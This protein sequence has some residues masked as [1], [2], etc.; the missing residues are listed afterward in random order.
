[1]PQNKERIA[2][3]LNNW[4]TKTREQILQDLAS[5]PIESANL[6][7]EQRVNVV[8]LKI[9]SFERLLSP[10]SQNP[11]D[12]ATIK[13]HKWALKSKPNIEI[14]TDSQDPSEVEIIKAMESFVDFNPGQI[15]VWISPAEKGIYD[16]SR[17]GIYQTILV[18]NEKYLFFR[19]LCG[20][21]YVKE[22]ADIAILFLAHSREKIETAELLNP[23]VLRATPIILD[24]PNKSLIKFLGSFIK[25][26]ATWE[27]ILKA[28]DI[29]MKIKTFKVAYE[30]ISDGTFQQIQQ[31]NEFYQQVQIGTQLERELQEKLNI[32]L[33]SGSCGI[34]Y[35]SIN[36]NPLA[37]ILGISTLNS[38]GGRRKH[39]GKCGKH[40]YFSDGESCPYDKNS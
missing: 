17:I 8:A 37:P 40:G 33:K 26:P 29:K 22:C 23:E 11:E 35:S 1:M 18:N 6:P 2:I 38:E 32:T 10:F 21:Q 3:D 36:T 34:L 5:F 30:L 39:C 19:S 13:I 28:E 25:T 4:R 16:G 7:L 20:N 12:I 31:A 15:T 14:W 27:A 24:V 9:T